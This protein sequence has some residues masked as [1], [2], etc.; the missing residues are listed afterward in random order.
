MRKTSGRDPG[1]VPEQIEFLDAFEPGKISEPLV[2]ER[3]VNQEMTFSLT[4]VPHLE[5]RKVVQEPKSLICDKSSAAEVAET[6]LP[7]QHL[8]GAVARR[9]SHQIDSLELIAE[10]KMAD[11]RI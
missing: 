8:D 7:L 5:C 11:A 10:S 1:H 3:A 9:R 2:G 4:L 6:W